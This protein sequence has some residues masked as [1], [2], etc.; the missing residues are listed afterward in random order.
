MEIKNDFPMTNAVIY[1][2]DYVITGRG[3]KQNNNELKMK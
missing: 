2:E 1:V 3:K